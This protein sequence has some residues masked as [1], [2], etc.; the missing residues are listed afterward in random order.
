MIL[1]MGVSHYRISM[2]HLPTFIPILV[3]AFFMVAVGAAVGAPASLT[4]AA[5]LVAVG[6]PAAVAIRAVAAGTA[7]ADLGIDSI[8]S[9]GG[10][11]PRRRIAGARSG[12]ARPIPFAPQLHTA[13]LRL[14]HP[15]SAD[16]FGVAKPFAVIENGNDL[17]GNPEQHHALQSRRRVLRYLWK[18]PQHELSYPVYLFRVGNPHRPPPIDTPRISSQLEYGRFTVSE[19]L[20]LRAIFMAF[21]DSAAQPK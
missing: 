17:S 3:L 12:G 7:D 9:R 16:K 15:Q 10:D 11:G 8:P 2:G 18:F 14:R 19:T 4:A 13:E 5:I 6:I 1:S 21:C 20:S